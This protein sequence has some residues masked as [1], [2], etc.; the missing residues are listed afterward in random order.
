MSIRIYFK[1]NGKIHDLLIY[2]N[3]I[4]KLKQFFAGFKN[5]DNFIP[6]FNTV[7]NIAKKI[8]NY[9]GIAI[10]SHPYGWKGLFKN[11]IFDSFQGIETVADGVLPP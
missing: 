9:N 5:N 2:F 4:N 8:K 3:N 1:I 6:S 7:E 11:K 10:V